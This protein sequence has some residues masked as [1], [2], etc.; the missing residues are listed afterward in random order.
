[1]KRMKQKS[2]DLVESTVDVEQQ[3]LDEYYWNDISFHHCF[4]LHIIFVQI[5]KRTQTKNES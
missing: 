3:I 2:S 1:M 5:E 4:P